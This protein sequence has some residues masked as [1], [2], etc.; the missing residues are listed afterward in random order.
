MYK[1]RTEMNVTEEC[2]CP[3]ESSL[4]MG[5]TYVYIHCMY[6]CITSLPAGVLTRHNHLCNVF[7]EFCHH[8]HLGVRVELGSGLTPDL[9][10]TWPADVQYLSSIGR[11][12]NM[13]PLTSR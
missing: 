9:T 13:L 7:V 12:G 1:G 11:E 8:A 6:I 4:L 3:Y 2:M 5:T 10:H